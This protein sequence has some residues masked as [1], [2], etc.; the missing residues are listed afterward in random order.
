VGDKRLS[1]PFQEALKVNRFEGSYISDATNVDGFSRW[2]SYR[3]NPKYGFTILVGIPTNAVLDE[4]KLQSAF[5]VGMT[6]VFLFAGFAY[7]RQARRAW[8]GQEQ[9]T[10]N[11][12]QQH[13]ELIQRE[14]KVRQLAFYDPLT[15][16]PN[17]RL[18]SDRL[19]Q[20]MA[21][22]KRSGNYCAL[23]F[24][25]LDNFKPLNDQ[26]GHRVGDLLLMEVADRIRSCIREIDTVARHGGD[27]FVVVISDIG[28]DK[29]QSIA[30]AKVVAE[31]IRSLLAEPY[32]LSVEHQ[33]KQNQ[34]VE[35]R[36]SASIGI[37]LFLNHEISENDLFA[38]ADKAMYQAKMAGRNAVRFWE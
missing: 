38:R 5:V 3:R 26:H 14:V 18:L 13:E 25:D 2:Y 35:H 30:Q 1:V 15:N 28:E 17:R 20:T 23:L 19:S 10:A 4:W 29:S 32:R 24:L 21:G 12:T 37:A 36:C 7:V 33:G 8:L 6:A 9:N 11:L 31:K 27:E 22:S 16:L 34:I